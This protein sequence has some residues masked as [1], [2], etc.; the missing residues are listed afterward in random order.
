MQQ[1]VIVRVLCVCPADGEVDNIPNDTAVHDAEEEEK[2][3]ARQKKIEENNPHKDK[4]VLQAKL[5]KL[6]IQIGYAGQIH[7]TLCNI[8]DA[9]NIAI[10]QI[11]ETL[12]YIRCIKHC[13]T[14][15]ALN[16][17]IRQIH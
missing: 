17:A 3:K 6:A 8:S 12:Q 5:T 13:N 15:D 2:R 10:H 14:P 9:L 16:I 4:S 11:H 7:R 1:C